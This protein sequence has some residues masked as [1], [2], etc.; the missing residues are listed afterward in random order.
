MA[1]AGQSQGPKH[2]TQNSRSLITDL[3]EYHGQKGTKTAVSAALQ[4][5]LEAGCLPPSPSSILPFL[6]GLSLI[7]QE[8]I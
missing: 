5:R 8:F 1:R 2:G 3:T 6:F 7:R 4:P